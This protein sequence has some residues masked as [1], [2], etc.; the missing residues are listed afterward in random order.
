MTTI[1]IGFGFTQVKL[2]GHVEELLYLRFK[3]IF[4]IASGVSE[5]TKYSIYA[6]LRHH[7]ILIVRLFPV[8][9]TRQ[10]IPS[11][12]PFIRIIGLKWKKLLC[13]V[14]FNFSK[15]MHPKFYI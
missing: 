7:E 9:E 2:G 3:V 12:V 13:L 14:Q 8:D 11:L 6:C 1:N 4:I 15:E 5:Q 10:K